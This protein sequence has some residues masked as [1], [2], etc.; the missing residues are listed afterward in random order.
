MFPYRRG[1]ATTCL[2]LLAIACVLS[3]VSVA[4][5][6]PAPTTTML[7]G[8][9]VVSRYSFFPG[10]PRWVRLRR[11]MVLT[12][13]LS[14]TATVGYLP[15]DAVRAVLRSAFARWAEAIPVSFA[16]TERYGAADITVGF[17]AGDHDDEDAFTG[18][19]TV[20]AHA[21]EPEDGRLHFNAQNHWAVDLSADSSPDAVDLE[22]VATHEIGHILGLD[23]ATSVSSVM[24]PYISLRERKVQLSGDDVQGIQE[25]YGVNPN[26][27][28][29]SYF[30]PHHEPPATRFWGLGLAYL[31]LAPF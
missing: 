27:S 7:H 2:L 31:L 4:A 11:P 12:Y 18:P 10:K 15:R 29:T 6:R 8:G 3:C 21:F 16:E 13:A 17:Y 20:F 23:H 19:Q 22:S 25:L 24:Y 26:F 30:K 9:A 14:K 1:G 28:F 5:A